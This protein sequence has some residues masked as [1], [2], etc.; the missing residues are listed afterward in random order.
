[1]EVVGDREWRLRVDTMSEGIL[2]R[3]D[4]ET[5][6]RGRLCTHATNNYQIINGVHDELGNTLSRA[7]L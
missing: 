6:G 7:E 2:E 1:M 5:R 3:M 4:G